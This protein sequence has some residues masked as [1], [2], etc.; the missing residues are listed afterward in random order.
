M[1]DNQSPKLDPR[2]L[3]LPSWNPN[4]TPTSER[5]VA[6]EE[7]IET[8][9]RK[10][11]ELRASQTQEEQEVTKKY[12]K[13]IEEVDAEKEQL[14]SEYNDLYGHL[15]VQLFVNYM[16]TRSMHP[17]VDW[18][19]LCGAHLHT[20]KSG[21]MYVMF[22]KDSPMGGRTFGISPESKIC[23][24]YF[25][26]SPNVGFS[27]QLPLSAFTE[28]DYYQG[29]YCKLAILPKEIQLRSWLDAAWIIVQL[30]SYE[31]TKKTM[32]NRKEIPKEVYSLLQHEITMEN[33]MKKVE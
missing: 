5:I 10:I 8:K 11:D 9:K 22:G 1:D 27:P 14:R 19:V 7:K 15:R 20:L 33:L 2:I 16:N 28:L 3:K 23:Y 31:P 30:Y 29:I 26:G 25:P 17:N 12:T 6:I 13:L 32:V 24:E 18:L 21:G 4:L